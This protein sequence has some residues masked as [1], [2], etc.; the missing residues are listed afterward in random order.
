MSSKACLRLLAAIALVVAVAPATA[1]ADSLVFV[2]AGHVQ[3]ARAD[4]SQARSVSPAG[5]WIWPSESDNGRIAAMST[6]DYKVYEFDQQGRSLLS[7]PIFTAASTTLGD[8][9]YYV[10]HIR[11]SPDGSR[12]AYNVV[13]CCGGSGSSTFLQPMSAGNSAWKDFQDDYIN[14]VWVDASTANDPYVNAKNGLGLGHNGFNSFGC[15]QY[16]IWNGDNASDSGSWASDA[17]IPNSNWEFEVAYARNLKHLALFLDDSPYYGSTAHNVRIVLESVNWANNAAET[18]NCTIPL[19]ASSYSLIPQVIDSISYSSDGSTLA[20][21]TGA[22]VYEANVA[23]PTNC[24]AVKNSVHLAVPGGSYPY[25]GAAALSAVAPPPNTAITN[26]SVNHSARK[27]TIRFQGSG[28]VGKLHFQCRLDG[29]RWVACTA[30]VLAANLRRGSNT[31]SV[32]A[33]DS[34]GKL[35]PTPATRTFNV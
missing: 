4:G 24:A 1:A 29:G 5:Q 26:V 28:G 34:R 12:M 20:W 9:S 10:N 2:K 13:G 22:G 14:P 19:S 8:A 31:F 21:A 6:N 15:C 18:V 16:G 7:A 32:E 33:I 23:D 27:A 3:V 25:F 35:D 30:P 17:A 11:I